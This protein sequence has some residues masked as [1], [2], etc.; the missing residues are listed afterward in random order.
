MA[1][2]NRVIVMGRLTRS[3]ELRYAP[4]GT[5][6]AKMGLASNR[7]FKQGD[8]LK[9]EVLFVDVAV[10]GKQAE[11]VSQY[12]VKGSGVLVEG[13]LS[14]SR[15]E[16]EDGQ[17]RSKHEIVAQSVIFMPKKQDG[18]DAPPPDESGHDYD[19]G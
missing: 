9:E 8:E 17:K 15:W 7:R 3:P 13:R 4:N 5:P 14:Q 10:F 19:Q 2:F 1:G 12:L 16:T 11:N 6:V 18:G